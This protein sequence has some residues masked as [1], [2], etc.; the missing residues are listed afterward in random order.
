MNI[1]YAASEV[2][3]FSQ[4]GGL[5]DVAGSL[6]KE[7]VK[8]GENVSVV[9]PLYGSIGQVWREQMTFLMNFNVKL[10]WRSQYCGIFLLKKDGVDYYF[11]DNEYYFKRDKPYGY[12]DDG[13]RFAFFSKAV[14]CMLLHLELR[15]Q[16]IHVN[17][18]H[19]ALI[20]VFI[21]AMYRDTPLFDRVRTVL[22]IHNINYQGLCNPYHL[23]DLLGLDERMLPILEFDGQLNFMKGGIVCCS[24]LTTVS[25]TYAEE[26]QT[27]Q[28]AYGLDNI[29]R[30]NAQKLTGIVNGIDE[31]FYNPETDTEIKSNF[32]AANLR[33]K[34]YDKAALELEFGLDAE[35]ETPIIAMVTRLV[36][37]KGLD[38]VLE[39]FERLMERDVRFVLL[40]SGEHNYCD[41]FEKMRA[42][43]PGRVG[44]Y[45]GFNG[46][47]ARK[48]Y[49]GSDLFLMPSATE[50]CG[51]SQMIAMR[52]ACVP[53]VNPVGGLKDTVTDCRLGSGNGFL[54][55]RYD[56]GDLLNTLDDAL[57]LYVDKKDWNRLRK[58][59]ASCDNTW[60]K[61]AKQYLELYK[62]I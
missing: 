43:Y 46:S 34:T 8:L 45:F 57:K 31:E 30:S 54:M 15:V 42:K 23:G 12:D 14:I 29:I 20:P 1:L 62:K 19:T 13:E 3:P 11:I 32:T 36:G 56:G 26:I 38:L 49:A 41:F 51:L 4:S 24:A 50:P 55:G 27:P 6:P 17:D 28:F 59:A 37:M 21:N 9:S 61:S 18:W 2:A 33:G 39:V 52:Y 7:L 47:L 40:G 16:V 44:V 5:G 10:A 53:V 25:P 22:T 58:Y 35:P 60:G 48:I